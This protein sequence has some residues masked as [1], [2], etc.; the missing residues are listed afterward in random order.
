GFERAYRKVLVRDEAGEPGA[1]VFHL[2]GSFAT[3]YNLPHRHFH[4]TTHEFGFCLG[5]EF[6]HWE[7]R[8]AMEQ[9][10]GLVSRQRGYFMSRAQ[11]SIHGREPGPFTRVGYTSLMWRTGT[12]NW[13]PEPNFEEETEVVDFVDDWQ[14]NTGVIDAEPAADGTGTIV[15]WAGLKLV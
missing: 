13:I 12:G 8:D 11:G 2:P 3:R 14:E 7:Y 4:R 10:G 15:D 6:P 9:H 1:F 5:G